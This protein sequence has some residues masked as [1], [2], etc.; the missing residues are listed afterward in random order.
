MP[1]FATTKSSTKRARREDETTA[2]GRA[3]GSGSA[4]P[5]GSNNATKTQVKIISP[6]AAALGAVKIGM[7]SLPEVSQQ[8]LMSEVTKVLRSGA[9]YCQE[10]D[11]YTEA[12]STSNY[13]AS[14]AKKLNIELQ[15][16]TK[17]VQESQAFTTLRDSFV[18]RME[19]VRVELTRDFTLPA[20]KFTLDAKEKKFHTMICNFAHTLAKMFIAQYDIQGYDETSAI[21]DILVYKCDE[22]LAPF[23][24]TLEGFLKLIM[25]YTTLR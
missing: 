17:D 8:L 7:K 21:L 4:T 1:G 12:K 15:A 22:F 3:V 13:I 5:V 18:K 2:N 16:S 11:K 14:S 20:S 25:N 24:I 9:Q 6:L 19:E 23:S 10:Y